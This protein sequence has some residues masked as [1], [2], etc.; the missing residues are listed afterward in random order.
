MNQLI[1]IQNSLKKSIAQ[2]L[3]NELAH[4]L[5]SPPGRLK[6]EEALK[7]ENTPK[8]AA[9]LIPIYIGESNELSILLTLRKTYQG[10][11]SGQISFPG[12]K[13]EQHETSSIAVA[14][15]EAEE[16]VG[17]DP[18]NVSILGELSPLYIPPSHIVVFPVLAVL[19]EVQEW[20][21]HEREVEKIIE[22]KLKDLLDEGSKTFTDIKIGD[23]T[24][25]VP[26]FNVNGSIIWGATAMILS[27]LLII[28]EK[29][30]T[31]D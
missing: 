26:C 2:G 21:I 31:N 6:Y 7:L 11:H 18:K 1:K 30:Q 8:K 20:I 22:I 3:P 9:V 13:F 29:R 4:G 16:E 25:K 28:W 14:L 19:N 15:R 24:R 27:E 17:I 10:V 12:G 5:F 23:S